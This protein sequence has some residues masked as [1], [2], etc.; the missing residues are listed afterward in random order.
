MKTYRNF[1]MT[2]E[3]ENDFRKYTMFKLYQTLLYEC[4]Y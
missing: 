1:V 3:V 4:W 2:G